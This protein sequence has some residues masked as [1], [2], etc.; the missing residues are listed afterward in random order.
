MALKTLCVQVTAQEVF[1]LQENIQHHPSECRCT[2]ALHMLCCTSVTPL[3]QQK[4][5]ALQAS[6]L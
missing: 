1:F 3:S 5:G 4:V 2:E 6:A